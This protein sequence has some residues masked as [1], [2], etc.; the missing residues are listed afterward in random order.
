MFCDFQT[1]TYGKWILAGEHAVLRGHPALVFPLRTKLFTLTYRC[2]DDLLH[3][4]H[5]EEPNHPMDQLVWRV[6]DEGLHLLNTPHEHLTGHLHIQNQVPLGVGLGASAALCVAIARWFQAQHPEKIDLFDFSKRLEHIFHG[7]SSGLDIAGAATLSGGVYFK[8]GQATPIAIHWSPQWFLSASGEV[9]ITS[10]CIHQ[11][12]TQWRE[13]EARARAIDQQMAHSV[14][15]AHQALIDGSEQQLA[16]AI[17]QAC[18]C[19]ENWG[20]ITDSLKMH[21]QALRDAGAIAVKPTGSGGGGH[22]LSLWSA[23]P[24]DALSGTLMPV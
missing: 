22:V 18:S 21:M 13:N 8:E 7:Q 9:G 6:L 20:L 15:Q 11:V 14:Y 2:S 3:L 10:R 16:E 4:T 1:T 12:Q 17:N 23:P 19:F 5:E 24:P